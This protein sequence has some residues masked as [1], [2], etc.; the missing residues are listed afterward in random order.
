MK[1]IKIIELME[2]FDDD[3]TPGMADGGRIGFDDGTP[4]KFDETRVKIPTGEFIGEGRDKSQ[5]F[6]I[7]N[8]T[9][10]SVKYTTSGAGGG[11]KKLYESIEEVKK[12]KLD[13]IPDEL[14]KIDSKRIKENINEV[15]YKNKKTG[16]IVKKYKPFI[17]LNK[18]TIPGQGAD[19]L[20]EAEGFVK[21]YFKANPKKVR[22]RDPEKDY[23]QKDIRRQFEK[24]LQGRTIKFG[25]PKGY[26]AHHMLPLAGKADVTDSDIAIIS[27]KMNAELAQFDKPMNKLV[28]E[29]YA[30]DFSK[31]GSLKRMDEINKEL[32]NIVKKAE[33]KL[34]KKYKGLIG[35]NKLTPVLDEFDTKGNQVFDMERIGAD[36]KKSI[37]GKKIGIPLRDIKTKE[38]VKQ[39]TDA[40]TFKAKI[41]VL[42]DI[43]EMA[44][45]IPDDIKRAKYLKGAFKT[46][47][48][49]ASPLIVYDTYKA[50]EQGKP[51]LEALEQGLIGTDAIGGTK[52]ILS[53]TP[54]ERT[55]RSVVKQDALKD[56]NL[57]MP[58]GFGFIEGPTPDTDMTLEEAQAK[59]AAGADRV[60]QLEAQK[61][62]E[63]KTNRANFFGNL[64][65][66]I[67]G[68][69]QSLSF[70]GGGIAKQAGIPSGPAPESGPNSQGL[71]GLIKRANN[72]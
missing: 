46:L 22:V 56:L 45:T 18:I 43:L 13:F 52:R 2:L 28:N 51:V 67:F 57:E 59:A 69:P 64:R 4:V 62:F 47:G 70:A 53:L 27:N 37:G 54:E 50:F 60:K 32:A 71:P 12:A 38:I 35:F 65:D 66:R 63:T 34:P 23:R 8:N 39:V 40:P 19:T 11:K 41:P 9:T 42:T 68:A 17:G 36:Y 49:A 15:T 24:D 6:K 10:G 26:T 30:L 3:D 1:D 44:K 25:A 72:L 20:K 21:D 61:N 29:A 31:E 55:A 58:M 33:T 16:K 48:I 7:K 14:V 5:I